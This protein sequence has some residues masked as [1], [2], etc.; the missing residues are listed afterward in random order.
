MK[1]HNDLTPS[2]CQGSQ[3]VRREGWPPKAPSARIYT[4]ALRHQTH[5]SQSA[6]NHQV[7]LTAANFHKQ[8]LLIRLIFLFREKCT[9]VCCSKLHEE[10]SF[11]LLSL[12]ITCTCFS[13]PLASPPVR[14]LAPGRHFCNKTIPKKARGNEVSQYTLWAPTHTVPICILQALSCRILCP[15]L[16]SFKGKVFL[17]TPAVRKS[18]GMIQSKGKV[19]CDKF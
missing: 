5:A 15:L 11:Q 3:G 10:Q 1:N 8:K 7:G 12:L 19:V 14:E 17:P 6:T 4:W 13:Y 9:A 2:L 18:G 16:K